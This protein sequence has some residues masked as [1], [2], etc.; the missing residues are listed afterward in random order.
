MYR[1]GVQL[2]TELQHLLDRLLVPAAQLFFIII[3]TRRVVQGAAAVLL[4][5]CLINT[6]GLC[7]TDKIFI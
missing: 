4:L 2:P 1:L 3:L 7:D 5:L 6:V